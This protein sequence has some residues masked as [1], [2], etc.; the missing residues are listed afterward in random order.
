[1]AMKIRKKIVA[2]IK[3]FLK[4]NGGQFAIR[5]RRR[6]CQQCKALKVIEDQK[7]D[8]MNVLAAIDLDKYPFKHSLRLQKERR[9]WNSLE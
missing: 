8:K 1:M 3:K 5:Q 4:T 6:P 2:K 9:K 7:L